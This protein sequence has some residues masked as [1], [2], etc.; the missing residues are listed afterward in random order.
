[1]RLCKVFRKYWNGELGIH[2]HDNL[3]LALNNSQTAHKNGVRWIDST[4]LGMGRGPGN[5]KTEDYLSLILSNKSN[6]STFKKIDRELINL[7]K[8]LKKRY[9]WGTNKYYR[10]SGQK[11]I[12]PTYIQEILSN[13]KNKKN[14][15]LSMLKGLTKLDVKKYNP[16]NMYFINNFTKKNS[17][18]EIAP[19][20]FFNNKKVLIVGPGNSVNVNRKKI[21]D[22][23]LKQ[24]L[25]VIYT[26]KVK[27]FMG[28]KNYYRIASHPLRLITDFNYHLK[29]KD[30][31]I[32]PVTN[33]P[34]NIFEKFKKNKKKMLNFGLEISKKNSIRVGKSSCSLPEPLIIGY[35]LCFVISGGI[36]KIYLTGFD[37]FKKDDP[38]TDTTQNMIDIFTK[39]LKI[40]YIKSLTKTDYKLN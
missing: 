10:Y 27:N 31:L 9:K 30:P 33:I 12:H 29:N 2:A 23:I 22:F 5:T 26:N 21:K 24:K 38:Y 4:I 1:M 18:E 39:K 32:L 20:E 6:I 16:L 13:R 15:I 35:S 7:F 36:K 34:Q 19:K 3:G 25:T 40:K 14:E 28:I 37:G 17:Y 8:I 11:K